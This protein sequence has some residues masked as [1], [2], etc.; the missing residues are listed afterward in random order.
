MKW[1]FFPVFSFMMGSGCQSFRYA[2]GGKPHH[3]ETHFYNNYDNSPKPSFLKWQWERF[4]T[5]HAPE[6]PFSPEIVKTDSEFLRQNHK[7]NTL[8]WIGHA[9]VFLQLDGVNILL[10]PVFSE[11]VSPLSFLGPKR[12]VPLPFELQALPAVDAVL[13][14]HNHYDHLDLPTLKEIA[15]QNGNKTRFFVPLGDKSLLN[16]EGI[17]NVYEADWWDKVAVQDLSITFVPSQHWSQRTFFDR[18]KSLWG[19][20]HIS[21][22]RL[23]L[24]FTGDT[25]YSKDFKDIYNKFGS[26]DV[27]IIPLGSY[28]PRWFMKL[29]HVNPDEALRVAEDLHAKLSIGVHWGTFHLSDEPL[30]APPRD[31][32]KAKERAQTKREFRLLKHGEIL[33][34]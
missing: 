12:Q 20:W 28:E 23:K 25:G 17:Q 16:S 19:G 11:R 15:K 26:I 27:A 5:S 30:D 22:S 4:T 8:T 1:T 3:G 9:S 2:A 7:V 32:E 29:F 10:D 34:L 33:N 24:L 13:I 6:P 14:S 21:S 31:L 18:N